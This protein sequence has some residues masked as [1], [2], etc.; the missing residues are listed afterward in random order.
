MSASG[1]AGAAA[2]LPPA[3]VPAAGVRL[4]AGPHG[5][6][7]SVTMM[8]GHGSHLN[9][10]GATTLNEL[11]RVET[12]SDNRSQGFGANPGCEVLLL[13]VLREVIIGIK[14]GMPGPTTT[15]EAFQDIKNRFGWEFGG[16]QQ[17]VN[18]RFRAHWNAVRQIEKMGSKQSVTFHGTDPDAAEYI[19]YCGFRAGERHVF[20][21]G[22]YMS[23]RPC[24]ATLFATPD[25]HK[26]Q[27]L[28]CG[29][30]AVG[31]SMVVGNSQMQHFGYD[32]ENRR[33]MTATDGLFRCLVAS[34]AEQVC[35]T[36]CFRIRQQASYCPR[37]VPTANIF[38]DGRQF[39]I[40]VWDAVWDLHPLSMQKL[41]PLGRREAGRTAAASVARPPAM[42]ARPVPPP[43]LLPA[44]PLPLAPPRLLPAVPLP[45]APPRLLP[46]VPLPP[47]PPPQ[48]P[49]LYKEHSGVREG[50]I[51]RTQDLFKSHKAFNNL[52]GE[53]VRIVQHDP[54]LA[55]LFEVRLVGDAGFTAQ[56]FGQNS[57]PKPNGQAQTLAANPEHLV[58]KRGQLAMG[59]TVLP[60]PYLEISA[61]IWA[62][63]Y[64]SLKAKRTTD[65]AGGSASKKRKT[66]EAEGGASGPS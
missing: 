46:P 47:V 56:L 37:T 25:R 63:F 54:R 40:M 35:P 16:V 8:Q 49:R 32:N 21:F 28:L 41:Y 65:K 30:F 48:Q 18:E 52:V 22:V 58:A 57:M 11:Q 3:A 14:P 39:H 20:G 59:E 17:I 50:S 44:V 38:K 15:V 29:D 1:T 26:W 66:N 23:L 34:K 4:A 2:V 7:V 53:V 61:D 43:H 10:D 51:V 60:D 33:I 31:H 27:T 9:A 5:G 45:L 55:V 36:F 19:K 42:L 64:A 12:D 6:L 24:Y 13:K 62:T